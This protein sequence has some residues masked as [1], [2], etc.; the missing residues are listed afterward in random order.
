MLDEWLNRYVWWYGELTDHG[1]Q[2]ACNMYYNGKN[3]EL[4]TQGEIKFLFTQ[5]EILRIEFSKP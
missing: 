1:R 2:R 5:R 3:P 4:L